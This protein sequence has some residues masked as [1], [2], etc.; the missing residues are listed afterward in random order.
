MPRP[1]TVVC[2]LAA[3]GW[4]TALGVFG[5][6]AAVVWWFP[7]WAWPLVLVPLSWFGFDVLRGVGAWVLEQT[8]RTAPPPDAVSDAA[9]AAIESAS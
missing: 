2:A 7:G 9:A 5:C 8:T 6:M 4:V 1:R 3:V